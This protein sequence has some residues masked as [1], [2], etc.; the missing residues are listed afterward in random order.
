[1]FDT[2]IK[3]PHSRTVLPSLQAQPSEGGAS[4]DVSPEVLHEIFERQVALRPE[5][6]AVVCGGKQVSYVELDRRA[7]QL[8]DLLRSRG[9]GPA[10]RAGLLL[11]RSLNVYVGLL[12][13]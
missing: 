3:G 10:A 4:S 12:G 7:N 11:P 8:A 2:S 1:M 6:V 13:I 9:I 5:Q